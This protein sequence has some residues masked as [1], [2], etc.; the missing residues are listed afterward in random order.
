MK[1]L[2][3]CLTLFIALSS[4]AQET[5][6]TY[7]E[8]LEVDAA[9]EGY[10]RPRIVL[11]GDGAPVIL[12]GHHLPHGNFLAVM[13]GTG[14][15]EPIPV[16]VPGFSPAVGDWF[17]SSIAA[18]GNTLWVVMK[19]MPETTSPM[20][21]RRSDDGGYTWGDTIRVEPDNGLISDLPSITVSD[22]NAPI[23]QYMEFD[24]GWSNARQVVSK[25]SNGSFGAPMQ[26]STP[27]AP[28]DVCD[29]CPNQIASE[30]DR[31]VALYR[32]AG[33]NERVIWGAWS[34]DG[35]DTFPHGAMVDTTNWIVFACPS[36][37]PDGV[38]SGDSLRY[39]W[40]SGANG[41]KVQF[42]SA[43][44]SDGVAFGRHRPIHVT[45]SDV[46][47]NFPRIAGSGDTLG[48]VWRQMQSGSG[49]VLFKWSTT[50]GDGFSD[51][52]TVNLQLNGIQGNPD[53]AFANGKFH[54]VWADEELE[55]IMYRQ[56][57][58]GTTVGMTE[59]D[60]GAAVRVWP[61]PA[62]DKLFVGLSNGTRIAVADATGRTVLNTTIVDGSLD[63]RSLSPGFYTISTQ[64]ERA[65]VVS[66]FQKN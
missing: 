5:T 38:I 48:V 31:V 4:S 17:G 21:V 30:G 55:Q 49:E 44:L 42:A 22:P 63:I 39:V 20:Y 16:H 13:D 40:M 66:R 9:G 47:Q 8:V 56:V 6:V 51:A 27:Y 34:D 45:P 1:H 53:I 35:G 65:Q 7:G 54:I 15:S 28:G 10:L 46:Q 37:G 12:W 52:D 32:N 60:T 11:N 58:I 64:D 57:S 36:T 26:V 23:V 59:A 50:G 19:G 24:A 33:S 25:M 3:P 2:L 29:C 18:A 61:N 41:T 62:K 43:H 14:F